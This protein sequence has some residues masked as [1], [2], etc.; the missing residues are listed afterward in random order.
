MEG[1]NINKGE[2]KNKVTAI[3]N[4]ILVKQKK[5]KTKAIKNKIPLIAVR[6][7]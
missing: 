2:T 4:D 7:G 5:Y 3:A 1:N 6:I